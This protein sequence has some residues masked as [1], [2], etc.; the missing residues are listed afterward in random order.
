MRL[1]AHDRMSNRQCYSTTSVVLI[2]I[3]LAFTS[4][5]PLILGVEGY[6]FT[7]LHSVTH[8][9]TLTQTLGGSP[10]YEGSAC[11]CT[12]IPASERPQNSGLDHAANGIGHLNTGTISIRL[13]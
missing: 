12:K 10:L 4:F 8:T 1:A 9:H 2:L 3:F 5:Y 7:R 6:C 11:T 13:L